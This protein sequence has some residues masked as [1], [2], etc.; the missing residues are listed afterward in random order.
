MNECNF[1]IITPSY[2]PDFERC[3]I[4]SWSINNFI[5]SK[6]THYIIVPERDL[7][8]FR[9]L[10]KLN[11]EII[12]VESILPNWIKRLP[13]TKKWWFS[14]KHV[15]IRGW[16]IQQVIKL[17]AAE[18]TSQD[19]LVFIDSDVAFIE[20]FHLESFIRDQTVRLFRV[21]PLVVPQT[22]MSQKWQRT[23]NYLLDLP[24]TD[25]PVPGYIGQIITW[26]RDCLLNL[27][28]HIEKVS[29]RGWVESICGVWNL[30]EY[31]LYGSYVD[32][33]LQEKSGHYHDY[34]K[35]CHEYWSD[36]PLSE[37][38]LQLFFSEKQPDDKAIMISAKAEIS[39]Q[40]YERLIKQIV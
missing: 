39:I 18:Y 27:C 5:S 12:T 14:A 13:Y 20:P 15:L 9:Q 36:E 1:A 34:T 6:F 8:L 21:P 7:N 38:Q 35:I 17:A 26:R 40:Q 16:I 10:Q 3:R 29:S 25:A 31:V 37:K 28:Q 32:Q 30:S 2:E 11:T 4:L 33:I 24:N 23:T 19:V 22:E